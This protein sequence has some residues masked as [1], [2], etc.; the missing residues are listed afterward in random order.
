[1]LVKETLRGCSEEGNTVA[2]NLVFSRVEQ[3]GCAVKVWWNYCLSNFELLGLANKVFFWVLKTGCSENVY[4][5][6]GLMRG[7]GYLY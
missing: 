5:C 3:L 1:M 2:F 6:W 4:C 7:Q